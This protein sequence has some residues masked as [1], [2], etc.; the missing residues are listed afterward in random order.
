MDTQTG[1][2]LGDGE[3]ERLMEAARDSLTDDM[4]TRLAATAGGAMDLIDLVNRNGLTAAIPTLAQIVQNGDLE[5]IAQLA[6]LV[7]SAQDA[8][9]DDMVGRLAETLGEGLSLLDRL[10]RAGVGHLIGALEQMGSTG[11]L[12]R[13]AAMLP[14]LMERLER[15]N[16]MLE[17]M[18]R[19][20]DE[21]V[22]ERPAGG[23]LGGLWQLMA[24]RDNQEVLR[25]MLGMGREL[26]SAYT[27]KK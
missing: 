15:M 21:L 16:A 3:L 7:G 9:T 2:I 22:R 20:A 25:F 13:L 23:G 27:R 1:S 12:E 6:R 10:N 26:R 4:V 14:T 17:S 19:A 24:N 18:E 8:M 11:A 5:R